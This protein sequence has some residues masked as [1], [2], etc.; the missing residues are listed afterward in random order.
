MHPIDL[1]SG[2]CK[3]LLQT[4]D[5]PG[6][7]YICW[8]QAIDFT[9]EWVMWNAINWFSWWL[10]YMLIITNWC[11]VVIYMSQCRPSRVNINACN[12]MMCCFQYQPMLIVFWWFPGFN[13]STH[14]PLTTAGSMSNIIIR[15]MCIPGTILY[16][17]TIMDVS[18]TFTCVAKFN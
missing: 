1:A 13:S 10:V 17:V 11:S 4:I 2:R 14:N 16:W 7:Q 12:L 3:S 8:L 9:R 6:D 5:L 15:K 18:F